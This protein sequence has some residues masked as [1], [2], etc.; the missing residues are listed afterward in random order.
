MSKITTAKTAA[1]ARSLCTALRAAGIACNACK[2]SKTYTQPGRGIEVAI[3]WEIRT[4]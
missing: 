4:A 1:A 3:W 2:I